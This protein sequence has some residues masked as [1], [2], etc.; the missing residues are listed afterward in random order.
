MC[1]I[2]GYI[3]PR[4]AAGLLLEGLRRL[5]YRGYDSS[6]IAVVNGNGLQIMKAAGKLSVL[7]QEMASP[8]AA[9]HPRHRAYALGHPRRP[10]HANAHP[11]TDQYRPHRGDPQRH[12][13]ELGRHPQGA[14]GA[15]HTLQDARPIPRCSRTWSASSTRATSRRRWPRRCATWTA[16]TASRSSRPTSPA[17]WWRRARARPLLV[18]RGRER[19]LRRLRRLAAAAAHAVG[20]LPRRRRDGRAHPRRLPGA[21]ISRPRASASR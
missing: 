15:G 21:R 4:Q 3:G 17:S 5:E 19:V 2:V 16:P 9:R 14:R 11:H 1:G 18:G 8:D 10:N 20:R 7:E 13:R 12:H 6:G